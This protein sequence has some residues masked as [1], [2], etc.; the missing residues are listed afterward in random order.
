LRALEIVPSY[1]G[2]RDEHLWKVTSLIIRLFKPLFEA[3]EL[4]D[5]IVDFHQKI[6]IPAGELQSNLRKSTAKYYFHH[7]AC[8][9]EKGRF[10]LI[11][12]AQLESAT[13]IDAET[14]QPV[15]VTRFGQLKDDEVVGRELFVI[16]PALIRKGKG[17]VPDL[18]IRKAVMLVEVFETDRGE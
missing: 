10:A 3:Q 15:R 9:D 13:M 1:L 5:I 12:K 18:M 8:Y 11:R 16:H 17:G 7:G 14:D 2:V 4:R 6:T